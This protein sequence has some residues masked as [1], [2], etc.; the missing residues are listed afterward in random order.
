MDNASHKLLESATH[1]T[2]HAHSF[3]RSS[4]QASLVLTDLLS[5]YLTLLSSTCT[6]YA[7]HAGRTSLSVHDAIGALDELGVSVGELSEYCSS[8]GKEL[9]RY[10]IQ[11]GRRAEDLNEF[12]AQLADGLRQDRD[13][14][15]PLVYAPYTPLSDYSDDEDQMEEEED[16]DA[17]ARHAV[18]AD[19]MDIDMPPPPRSTIP[20]GHI[21]E[22]P[23]ISTPPL[24]L[25]PVSNPSSPSRKRP[26][27][28]SWQPP[29]HV[30][31]FLPPFP[32]TEAP[33]S[34][35][36]IQSPEP[37]QPLFEPPPVPTESVKIEKP[38][39]TIGQTLTSSSASDY[40]VQ[41]PYSQSSLSGIAEWH[42]PSQPP[43][44]PSQTLQTRNSRLP[45]P[46]TEPALFSA[47]HHI[48]THPPPAN[49][50]PPSL[51]RHK[52]AM[53]LLAQTQTTPRWDPPDTLYSSVAPCAP[54]VATIGPTYPMA[55][56]DSGSDSKGKVDGKDKDFKFP[57]TL[58][59]PVS[60]SERLTPLVSQQSSRIPDL[61]RNVL[62]PTI[63]A[64][65]SRLTHP[66]ALQRGSKVLV[67]GSGVPAPWNA[68]ALPL[69]GALPATPAPGKAK[70]TEGT[71]GESPIKPALPDA[72]LYATWDYEPKDFRIPLVPTS[73]NRTRMGSVQGGSGVISLALGSRGKSSNDST[74]T[75][76]INR[77]A[78]KSMDSDRKDRLRTSVRRRS[79]IKGSPISSPGPLRNAWSNAVE[80]LGRR[81]S[82]QS[83]E[84]DK[85]GESSELDPAHNDFVGNT[86]KNTL[87]NEGG[88]R[89][90]SLHAEALLE[91][92]D[93]ARSRFLRTT[94]F[95]NKASFLSDFRRFSSAFETP[96]SW[97]SANHQDVLQYISDI[98][99]LNVNEQAE[100]SIWARNLPTCERQLVLV[101]EFLK[102]LYP[103][104]SIS[105]LTRFMRSLVLGS[106]DVRTSASKSWNYITTTSLYNHQ[107]IVE[108][109]AS[110]L[111]SAEGNPELLM[112]LALD[113]DA[114]CARLSIVLNN[115]SQYR[116]LINL[117]GDNAQSMLDLLQ[118]I[119]DSDSF[120]PSFR[121]PFM[122]ALL[123]LSRKSG[124]FPTILR[125]Q[126]VTLEGDDPLA[127]GQFGDVWKGRYRSQQVAVK[128]LKV[129]L[130]SDMSAHLRNVL[131]ETLIWRQLRHENVLPF[132]CL[133]YVNNNPKRIAL[134]SPWMENG[135][136]R[137][138]LIHY[139]EMP[140]I[141][142]VFDIAE[143][144]FYLHTM[145]PSI[146]HGD[147]K[148]VNILI[149]DTHRACLA[150]FGL[151][152]AS[153]SQ[154]L[155]LSSF[156][157][158]RVGGT[159]RWTAPELLNGTQETNTTKSDIYA[160][161]C[162]CYEI[163]SGSIPFHDIS[164]DYAVILKV[165]AGHRPDRPSYCE[166]MN[167]PCE[168]LGLEDVMWDIIEQ[169]WNADVQG[170]PTASEIIE[171]LMPCYNS[172]YNREMMPIASSLSEL[173]TD[174]SRETLSTTTG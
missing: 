51:S 144:L 63:M 74:T 157:D 38:P 121:S 120:D 7:Q 111:P 61:A 98:A 50:N 53:A 90:L 27:K 99:G 40:L 47:Y 75:F 104:S 139:P 55:I 128:V 115:V 154:V 17:D 71:R 82:R 56:G 76:C 114:L 28:A 119:L 136:I 138:F 130:Q 36:L 149:S 34:P 97:L 16:G 123:R 70:D 126:E 153:E 146:V 94:G 106:D 62:P 69:A 103:D 80:L 140:R 91:R 158:A 161:A 59:R 31:D 169:C 13:D 152:T 125:Q 46:Q 137:D 68:N 116:R 160:F 105:M 32:T 173:Q 22:A 172:A 77:F 159:S 142:F 143:G 124:L 117:Q 81:K 147:L 79:T 171:L 112:L 156:S 10:A 41:V 88:F 134:V 174:R 162:V 148:A 167:I 64:R 151:S 83:P 89:T 107:A 145:Q 54:R 20:F 170:R 52:V 48:L 110:F 21:P 168:T 86:L 8:E 37:T 164:N 3:S 11:S 2:L 113:F 93:L 12:K 109:F 65:T 101:F 165:T 135:N 57:P 58:P 72:R 19:L 133:H 150:D 49:L 39:L 92:D 1:R 42:L 95:S 87:K 85:P 129:Y 118:T 67:Y 15:I 23:R 18:A 73:R 155:H 60:S 30:P 131:H 6:K 166:P 108:R 96:E 26:R 4:S 78:G 35:I 127:N 25:S 43:P 14:T 102:G 132:L 141:P 9:G 44:P 163:F 84:L 33:P 100:C 5:R 45:T 24:P 29:P 122:N 66:P